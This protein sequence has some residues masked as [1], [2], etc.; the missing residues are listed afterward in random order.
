[1]HDHLLVGPVE[2][3]P[4]GAYPR[5]L[6]VAEGALDSTLTAVGFDNLSGR[7][8]FPRGSQ[9]AQTEIVALQSL[10]CLLIDSRL[11]LNR[12]F[13]RFDFATQHLAHILAVEK[14]ADLLLG[15]CDPVARMGRDA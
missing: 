10:P 6:E 1:M 2:L 12:P 14:A 9:Q 5:V 13:L 4:E 3:R 7:P 15:P 8:F 11:K